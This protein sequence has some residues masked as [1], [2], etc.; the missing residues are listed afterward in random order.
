MS[1]L[2]RE[3][4]EVVR[5]SDASG[6][7]GRRRP[8]LI[9]EDIACRASHWSGL[10]IRIPTRKS[11]AF[12]AARQPPVLGSPAVQPRRG[13]WPGMTRQNLQHTHPAWKKEEQTM[14]MGPVA[15]SRRGGRQR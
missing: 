10:D 6:L 15:P 12:L 1:V 4:R 11:F 2:A 8:R 9:V 14:T 5:T 7:T 13:A 3:F